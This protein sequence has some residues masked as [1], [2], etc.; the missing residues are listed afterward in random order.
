MIF[1]KSKHGT[2]PEHYTHAADSVVF[3]L[4]PA[5][6]DEALDRTAL[7]FDVHLL[8]KSI[9]KL[10]ARGFTPELIKDEIPVERYLVRDPD[11]RRVEVKWVGVPC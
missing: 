7:G 2:G 6:T 3:E 8:E 5:R 1:E 10:R 11:N 9:E 4:Y